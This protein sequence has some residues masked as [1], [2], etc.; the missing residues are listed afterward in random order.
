M[1]S[2]SIHKVNTE[3]IAAAAAKISASDNTINQAFAQVVS[4]CNNMA[5]SWNSPAGDAAF[6]TFRKL[7]QGNHSRSAVLQNHASTL[8]K[9][10]IPTYDASEKQNTKLADLFL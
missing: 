1:P 8:Q 7:V 5:C 4:Q 10:V 3:G 6:E 2:M 9:V